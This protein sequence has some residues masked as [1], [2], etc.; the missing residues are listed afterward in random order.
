VVVSEP[1]SVQW[2]GFHN[3]RDLGGLP[4]R[5]GRS[6]RPG[7][8]YRSATVDFVTERGWREAYDAGVRT[9]ID[10][11]NDDEVDSNAAPPTGIARR[12]V[13]LDGIEDIAFWEPFLTSGLHGTPLYYDE[14]LKRKSDRVAAVI[15][16]LA[17]SDGGV[18]FHCGGGRDRTGLISLMLL[19]LAGVDHEAILDDYSMDDDDLYARAALL[20][21][22]DD[23]TEVAA[24]LTA[25]GTD[26]QGVVRQTLTGPD[27][28]SYL[29]AAG[30]C[31]ADITRLRARL[32][33]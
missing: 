31:D 24:L 12:R 15:T 4:L 1:R 13:P 22:P 21:R 18:V 6:S 30:V 3:A 8:F 2:E 28:Y 23:R 10:L 20:G 7:A 16:A 5:D 19:D 26:A 11:R 25:H 27:P 32:A 33:G 17:R 14:F 9:V 29:V